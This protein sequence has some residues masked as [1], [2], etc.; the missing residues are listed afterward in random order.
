MR[1]CRGG[2]YRS[3]E[4][5]NNILFMSWVIKSRRR[6]SFSLEECTMRSHNADRL[7]LLGN[8]VSMPRKILATYAMGRKFY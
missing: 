4:D 1:S 6:L 7:L 3:I 8:N 2:S 5:E